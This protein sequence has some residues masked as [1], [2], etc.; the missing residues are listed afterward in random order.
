MPLLQFI[1]VEDSWSYRCR[2]DGN[3][4]SDLLNIRLYDVEVLKLYA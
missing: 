1:V 4:D 3:R 2:I